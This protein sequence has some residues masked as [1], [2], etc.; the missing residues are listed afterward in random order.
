MRI[1]LT[2]HVHVANKRPLKGVTGERERVKEG[3]IRVYDENAMYTF[4][5]LVSVHLFGELVGEKVLNTVENAQCRSKEKPSW[6]IA[7]G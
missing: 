5:R 3:P 6:E 4:I 7:L 1:M 2:D